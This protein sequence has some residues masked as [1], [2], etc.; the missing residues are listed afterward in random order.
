MGSPD[1]CDAEYRAWR[2]IK[3][4][5]VAA[6]KPK[7]PTLAIRLRWQASFR[8]KLRQLIGKYVTKRRPQA[9]AFSFPR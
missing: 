4:G 1:G 3:F 5:A 2:K 8:K 9:G 6:S 7:T